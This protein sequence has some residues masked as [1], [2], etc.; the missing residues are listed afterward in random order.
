MATATTM[1]EGRAFCVLVTPALK[2]L[3]SAFRKKVK[4][5]GD[6][7]R[8]LGRKFSGIEGVLKYLCLSRNLN[9]NSILIE[10][11]K[12]LVSLMYQKLILH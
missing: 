5:N 3:K 12:Y 7:D 1:V 2:A 6:Y 8:A 4:K 11:L 10:D 9:G